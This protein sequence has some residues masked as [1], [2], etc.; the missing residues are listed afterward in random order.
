MRLDVLIDEGFQVIRNGA[1]GVP[2]LH[3]PH[4]DFEKLP[5]RQLPANTFNVVQP[6][7][8]HERQLNLRSL[9][10]LSLLIRRLLIDDALQKH[11]IRYLRVHLAS[12][13]QL[14]EHDLQHAKMALHDLV[15]EL[16][17]LGFP[18]KVRSITS[19]NVKVVRKCDV[20]FAINAP[21]SPHVLPRRLLHRNR[22]LVLLW[23]L[24][25]LLTLIKTNDQVFAECSVCLWAV[26][27]ELVL[28]WWKNCSVYIN[29]ALLVRW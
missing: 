23:I 15:A 9:E 17:L 24:R 6:R 27:H 28:T 18:N 4:D 1:L 16:L 19:H 21:L 22:R 11:F 14:H 10:T 3:Q 26:D 20:F 29:C 2:L 5:S 25:K 7:G 13:N 8:A 12:C